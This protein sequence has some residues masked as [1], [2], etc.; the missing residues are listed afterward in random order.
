VEGPVAFAWG[1]TEWTALVVAELAVVLE[2]V[3]GV[4]Q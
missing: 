4:V 3:T 2:F 1:L